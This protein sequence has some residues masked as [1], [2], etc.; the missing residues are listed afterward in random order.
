M[1]LIEEACNKI[2]SP[3]KFKYSIFD[4]GIIYINVRFY[5]TLKWKKI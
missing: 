3:P 4:L 2:V 5:D 1:N